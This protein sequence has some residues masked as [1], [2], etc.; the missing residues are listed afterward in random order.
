MS[1][2]SAIAIKYPDNT[3][4]AIYCH[5]DGYISNQK[6]ILLEHYTD[7]NKVQKLIELGDIS[8]LAE[9]IGTKHDFAEGPEDEV[10][11]YHRDRGDTYREPRYAD[12]WRQAVSRVG[13]NGYIYV[14]VVATNTW[15][16][17][18][19]ECDDL[20]PLSEVPDDT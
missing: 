8:S 5:W 19:E 20:I 18:S 6:P 15:M 4:K 3:T 7:V 16:F 13:H 12:T 1:T 17:A 10:T 14:F 11:A 9:N 2:R